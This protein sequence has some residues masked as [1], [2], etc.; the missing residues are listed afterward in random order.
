[1]TCIEGVPLL[2][3]RPALHTIADS[4]SSLL[5][6]T[7]HA[8]RPTQESRCIVTSAGKQSISIGIHAGPPRCYVST[9][10]RTRVCH[11]VSVCLRSSQWSTRCQQPTYISALFAL[12]CPSNLRSL[13]L[14]EAH[15]PLVSLGENEKRRVRIQKNPKCCAL[16]VYVGE[17]TESSSRSS[18]AF[19]IACKDDCVILDRAAILRSVVLY[20]AWQSLRVLW[21]SNRRED[22]LVIMTGLLCKI[23][24]RFRLHE[25]KIVF[26]WLHGVY[27]CLV[28]V[29]L[30]K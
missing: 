12:L 1:M 11:Q 6:I 23:D 4:A 21:C 18:S 22:V 13:I 30:A 9:V 3:Y 28:S 17:F 16:K 27:T 26:G 29:I 7:K 14:T 10:S 24:E 25:W 20:L 19:G 8:L 5:S 2:A 15:S